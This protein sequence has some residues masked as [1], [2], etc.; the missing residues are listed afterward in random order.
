MKQVII[1]GTNIEFKLYANNCYARELPGGVS[2]E[3]IADEDIAAIAKFLGE[4]LSARRRCTEW[5]WKWKEILVSLQFLG[6]H[7]LI[8]SIV[9]EGPEAA[10]ERLIEIR[11]NPGMIPGL[12][13]DHEETDLL[14][15]VWQLPGYRLSLIQGVTETEPPAGIPLWVSQGPL[16]VVP[17]PDTWSLSLV[18]PEGPSVKVIENGRPVRS[19]LALWSPPGTVDLPV[20]KMAQ[21]TDRVAIYDMARVAIVPLRAITKPKAV[22][23]PPFWE[24]S[25]LRYIAD[26]RTSPVIY[27]G[28]SG[29][30]IEAR[31]ALDLRRSHMQSNLSGFLRDPVRGFLRV[32]EWYYNRL[33][34]ADSVS[35]EVRVK[36]DPRDNPVTGRK[37]RVVSLEAILLP[38]EELTQERSMNLVKATI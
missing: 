36:T 28:P 14:E 15:V 21:V 23:V 17:D 5:V 9:T 20:P 24:Y 4:T 3:P 33:G 32:L 31:E 22:P 8:P 38:V 18:A 11:S 10:D 30:L 27:R 2:T 35:G 13:L 25:A 6:F 7:D 12:G 37:R 16:T 1:P 34:M 26:S 29:D 19:P